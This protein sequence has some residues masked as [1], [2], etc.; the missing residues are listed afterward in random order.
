MTFRCIALAAEPFAPLFA[1]DD[2][3]LA[4]RD[5]RRMTVDTSPGTPCRVSLIDAGVGET[6]LLLPYEHHAVASPYRASGPIFVRA[7]ASAAQLAAGEVAAVLRMR[8]LSLRAYGIDG[9]IRAAEVVEGAGMVAV[10]ARLFTDAGVAYLHAH[11]AR[12]GCFLCRV[13]RA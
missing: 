10:I 1:L 9:A 4:A 8:L 13:E 11:A 5:I 7:E 2:A 3:T 6:V 12:Y